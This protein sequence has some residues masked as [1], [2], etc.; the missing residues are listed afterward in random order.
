MNRFFTK[1]IA[2]VALVGAFTLVPAA[3]SEAAFDAWICND[4]SCNGGDDILVTDGGGG[5]T[6]AGANG[7][8]SFSVANYNGMT[9]TLNTAVSHP[10]IPE[11]QMDLLF[12]ATSQGAGEVYVWTANDYTYTGGLT[13]NIG[14]TVGAGATVDAVVVT[15]PGYPGGSF[16]NF[17]AGPFGPG[18]APFSASFSA[19][20]VSE[21]YRA[22]LGVHIVHTQG[23]IT[24]GDF[25]LVP[26][27]M[28]LSLLGLGLAGLAARR[29][30][31]A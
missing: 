21:P 10:Q 27:P 24:S 16:T 13:A 30:R 15:W 8:I 6:S 9:F 18:P 28:T 2:L 26:E 17:T 5:D 22:W 1:S 12:L 29:R 3:K 25:H 31:S 7:I 19:G 11:P 23:S 4:Y 14:G 20:S